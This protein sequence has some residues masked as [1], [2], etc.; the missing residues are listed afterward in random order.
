[1]L[2]ASTSDNVLTAA[3]S[4]GAAGFVS[5]TSGLDELVIAVRAACAGRP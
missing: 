5:K 1:M 2:T 4:A 3:M